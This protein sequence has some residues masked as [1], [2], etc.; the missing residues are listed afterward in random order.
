MRGFARARPPR[1]PDRGARRRPR[2]PDGALALAL[3]NARFPIGGAKFL[4]PFER[5]QR[6]SS[7]P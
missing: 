1:A 5:T 7:V 6:G 2:F 3:A 4:D